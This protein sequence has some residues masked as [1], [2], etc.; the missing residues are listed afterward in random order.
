MTT[1]SPHETASAASAETL[2]PEPETEKL[3]AEYE[4]AAAKPDPSETEAAIE[5]AAKKEDWAEVSRL[6][7]LSHKDGPRLPLKSPRERIAEIRALQAK[8]ASEGAKGGEAP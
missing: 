5:A 1:E 6:R 8:A 4:K 2:P 3:V 7:G